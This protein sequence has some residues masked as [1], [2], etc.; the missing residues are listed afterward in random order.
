MDDYNDN[1]QLFT[2]V[3]SAMDVI[4]PNMYVTTYLKMS[5]RN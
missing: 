3:P 5:I 1:M 4:N 2:A